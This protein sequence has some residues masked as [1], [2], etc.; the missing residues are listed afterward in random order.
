MEQ[1]SRPFTE[2]I[3]IGRHFLDKRVSIPSKKTGTTAIEG[4]LIGLVTLDL[5]KN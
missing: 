2:L 5:K 4:G 1:R 3:L